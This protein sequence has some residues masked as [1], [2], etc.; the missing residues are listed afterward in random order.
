[1][2]FEKFCEEKEKPA[3]ISYAGY[4]INE[5]WRPIHEQIEKYA[6]NKI[7]LHVKYK[8]EEVFQYLENT[9][10]SQANVLI[11]QYV[12]S[13]FYNTGQIHQIDE[14]FDKIIERVIKRRETKNPFIILINDVNS[15]NRG[16]DYFFNLKEKLDNAGFSL[17]YNQYYFAYN[18]RDE[19]QIYGT[20]HKNNKI[21]FK[22]KEGL[23]GYEP[24]KECSS[25]Q[26]LIELR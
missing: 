8:Y 20:R 5:L 6:D 13:H 14:F 17:W 12:I 1:M 19:H 15:C 25:A 26:M 11:L 21:C 23:E 16:R 3:F 18:I 7:G 9:N 10:I 4:D 24:W 22:L 2:A